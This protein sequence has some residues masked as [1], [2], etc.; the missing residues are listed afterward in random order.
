MAK[1]QE[2]NPIERVAIGMGVFVF[3]LLMAT[4]KVRFTPRARKILEE[5]PQGNLFLVWHNRLAMA[6]MAFSKSKA[7]VPLTGLVSTSRDGAAL[8]FVMERFNIEVARGSSSRRSVEA[9]RELLQAVEKG[10]NIVI[11]PDGPRGP[12]YQMKEGAA[13][14]SQKYVK[15]TYAV[16][17]RAS[18][19]WEFSSWDKFILPKPFS[20]VT[21]D[22]TRQ[23]E[24]ARESLEKS[25]LE[26]N[27]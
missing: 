18:N 8:T 4:V 11:T 13:I 26:N 12:C 17:L 6:L 25:L 16:G 19:Y 14:I 7:D 9:T 20:T 3:R 24:L 22:L 5:R 10:R 27:R 21:V 2:L 15:G 23:E 1:V